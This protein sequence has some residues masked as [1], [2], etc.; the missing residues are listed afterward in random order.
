MRHNAVPPPIELAREEVERASV[1][2]VTS[3]GDVQWTMLQWMRSLP[4]VG[5]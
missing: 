2:A 5:R 4:E 1:K 3:P